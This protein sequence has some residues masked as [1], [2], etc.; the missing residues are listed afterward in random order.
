MDVYVINLKK[1]I[2]RKNYIKQL[3]IPYNQYFKLHFI[4]AV[5][6]RN[7]PVHDLNKMYDQNRAYEIYGR[8]L[9]GAEVG[10]ALSHRKCCQK[11][12]ESENDV[13][14]VVED[15]LVWQNYDI[16]DI[17]KRVEVAMK[18]AP[19]MIVLLSGDYWFTTVEH[20]D[21]LQ[22]AN[23]REAV[24]SHA[25]LINRKAAERILSAEKC[26]L[27]DDWY[28]FNKLGI[29]LQGVYPHIAD[30]NRKDWLTEI[31]EDYAGTI[32]ENLSFLSKLHSYYR[33]V[34]KRVLLYT[35]HFESKIFLNKND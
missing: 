1:S 9:K 4:E 33:A 23:V 31:S 12:L 27:A 13:V 5:D 16:I 10:C 2:E 28:N 15:D 3:F 30:Q 6:C 14:L 29:K 7:I 34:I 26:Y 17:L 20:H 24:C 21:G 22:L 32:R 19:P 11:L 18:S 35:G 25:Y 8:T